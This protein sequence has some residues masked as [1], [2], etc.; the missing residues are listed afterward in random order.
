MKISQ[1]YVSECCRGGRSEAY[2]FKWRFSE[3]VKTENKGPQNWMSM[4][5]LL[6]IKNTN[7]SNFGVKFLK[8]P[9]GTFLDPRKA[10][11]EAR[12][13]AGE[14]VDEEEGDDLD[15][16]R[17]GRGVPVEQ[18]DLNSDTL[19]RRYSSQIVAG[20]AL[21]V[22]QISISLCC[23]GK[24]PYAY[25]F[26]WRLSECTEQPAL[27]LICTNLCVAIVE[28]DESDES[29]YAPMEQ[30]L[31]TKRLYDK[32]LADSTVRV[33][34]QV[35][36]ETGVVLHRFRNANEACSELHLSARAFFR[37]LHGPTHATA[38]GCRWRI[39]YGPDITDRKHYVYVLL[40]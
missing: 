29:E 14:E 13:E 12:R 18:L 30:L 3:D 33:I 2:G 37:C 39:Y 28:L 32:L 15:P 9:D 4:A 19:L 26:K 22:N 11:R 25:G 21:G 6:E 7:K 8:L 24:L 5:E 17:K 35:D 31:E 20:Q 34:E 16:R 1:I 23:R 27:S 36:P 38:Y 40:L 10:A